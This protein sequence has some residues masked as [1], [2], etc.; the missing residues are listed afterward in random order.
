MIWQI[1][2]ATVT[3]MP[4]SQPMCLVAEPLKQTRH[5]WESSWQ[6]HL[7]WEKYSI[8]KHVSHV[9]TKLCDFS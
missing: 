8:G 3:Q 6:S 7:L 5:Q 4:F 1:F 9:V 2:G